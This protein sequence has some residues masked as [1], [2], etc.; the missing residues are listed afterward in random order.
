MPAD[1]FLSETT[2]DGEDVRVRVRKFGG[3]WAFASQTKGEEG[4]NV[5]KTPSVEQLEGLLDLLQKKY[6]R[7]RVPYEDLLAV[8]RLL[9]QRK[10]P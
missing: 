10:Q 2:E 6:Q 3:K 5:I 4:W 7:Q 9:Q 8:E 1:F